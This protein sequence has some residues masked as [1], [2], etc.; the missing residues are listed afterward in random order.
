MAACPCPAAFQTYHHVNHQYCLKIT[1]KVNNDLLVF[2]GE[3]K[4]VCTFQLIPQPPAAPPSGQE[5]TSKSPHNIS[6][7]AD[8]THLEKLVSWLVS[9]PTDCHILFHDHTGNSSTTSTLSASNKPSG[10]NKKDMQAAIAKHIFEQDDI[11]AELYVS[12]P[13]KFLTSLGNQL[14]IK[15]SS[16]P[17]IDHAE[18]FLSL[19]QQKMPCDGDDEESHGHDDDQ[20]EHN[21]EGPAGEKGGKGSSLNEEGIDNGMQMEFGNDNKL[22]FSPEAL[23]AAQLH[24]IMVPPATF[25]LKP[26]ARILAYSSAGAASCVKADLYEK[27][28]DFSKEAEEASTDWT[29]RWHQEGLKKLEIRLKQ[30]EE[31]VYSKQIEALQLQVWLAKLQGSKQPSSTSG[32]SLSN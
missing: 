3:E 24:N 31:N 14:R 6:W 17:N 9:H 8:L 5:V 10:R 27:L 22:C 26:K 16:K 19:V 29:R 21:E 1:S 11:Y 28:S 15:I 20:A 13:D 18:K 25:T 2:W 23:L 32:P 12:H 7:D 4:F 30:V